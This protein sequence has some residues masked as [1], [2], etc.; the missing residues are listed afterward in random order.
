MPQQANI[1]KLLQTLDWLDTRDSGEFASFASTNKILGQDSSKNSS[2]T[3][4][5][6]NK[7]QQI[8]K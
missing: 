1:Y 8:I 3:G 4:K 7:P 5:Q 2:K 6:T